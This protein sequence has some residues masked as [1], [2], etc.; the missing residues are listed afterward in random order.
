MYKPEPVQLSE[1]E[2]R[3]LRAIEDIIATDDPGLADVLRQTPMQQRRKF[4]G[5]TRA[6]FIAIAV[7]IGTFLVIA[8][9]VLKTHGSMLLLAI[10]PALWWYIRW[11]K[12]GH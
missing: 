4:W 6:W 3:A 8:D 7:L 9:V 10:L 11:S 12:H 2:R 5:M 1:H